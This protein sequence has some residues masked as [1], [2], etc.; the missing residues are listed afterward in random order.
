MMM[1]AGGRVLTKSAHPLSSFHPR[2]RPRDVHATGCG[3]PAWSGLG[4]VPSSPLP[5]RGDYHIVVGSPL[6][7]G[8]AR[9]PS[10]N[11]VDGVLHRLERVI[12]ELHARYRPAAGLP[13]SHGV[14]FDRSRL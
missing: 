9:E 6:E 7:V 11:D 3:L 5:N 14:V 12:S 13:D 10:R 8:P 2:L 4:G 1:C